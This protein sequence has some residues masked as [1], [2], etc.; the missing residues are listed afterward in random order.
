M[1]IYAI[2]LGKICD[3]NDF[4]IGTPILN[5]ANFKEKHTA[6]MF[7][8]TAPLR[9][10]LNSENSFV[11]FVKQISSSSLSMLRYQKYPYQMLLENL[12][13]KDKNFVPN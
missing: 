6:G 8:N 2:Y 5:R 12:R 1:A 4:V 3:L 10:K 11:D 13:K 9:I 7:I